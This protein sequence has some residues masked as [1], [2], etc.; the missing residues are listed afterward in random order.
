MRGHRHRRLGD[1]VGVPLLFG[2]PE[3]VMVNETA[4]GIQLVRFG[5][6]FR[7]QAAV[8][9][10]KDAAGHEGWVRTVERVW[11][12]TGYIWT[13]EPRSAPP[14]FS[15]LEETRRDRED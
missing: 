1:L 9:P 14:A 15:A 3:R 5:P 13:F 10:P 2:P 8:V 7:A 12:L 11:G 4:E 6:E